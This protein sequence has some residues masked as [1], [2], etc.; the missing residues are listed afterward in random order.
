MG[1]V[2]KV[3]VLNDNCC[4]LVMDCV[5]YEDVGIDVVVVWLDYDGGWFGFICLFDDCDEV[6]CIL[7]IY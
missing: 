6:G 5:F 7:V 1:I 4:F 2:W 3:D